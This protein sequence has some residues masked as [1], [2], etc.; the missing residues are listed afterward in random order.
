MQTFLRI[1]VLGVF[2]AAGV[3]LAVPVALQPVV[4]GLSVDIEPSAEVAVQP[5]QEPSGQPAVVDQAEPLLD[6]PDLATREA[7]TP[8]ATTLQ[9]V[10][11]PAWTANYEPPV[12]RQLDSLQRAIDTIQAKVMEFK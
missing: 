7:Q 5:V 2:A 3:A 8:R 11:S 4:P 6:S 9:L 12:S 10:P 1:T